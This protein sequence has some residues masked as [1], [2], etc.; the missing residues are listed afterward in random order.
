M[1]L[2]ENDRLRLKALSVAGTGGQCLLF[3]P[4]WSE[5]GIPY[6]L[7]YLGGALMNFL[8]AALFLVLYLVCPVNALVSALFGALAI[9][10]LAIGLMNAIP[11]RLALLDND[12]RSLLSMNKNPQAVFAFYRMMQIHGQIAGGLRLKDM[13]DEWFSTP[14]EGDL[15]NSL[16]AT[17]EVYRCNRLLDE[18]K[19]AQAAERIRALTE[20][21]AAIA[22]IHRNL[23]I[24]DLAY[25]ALMMGDLEAADRALDEQQ[26]KFMKTM[27]HFPSILRTQYADSLLSNHDA[28]A[29]ATILARFMRIA[30]KYPYPS[31]IE[32]ER[33]LMRAAEACSTQL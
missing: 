24:C 10:G 9:T 22:G 3:P 33:E 18:Q 7:Y 31:D 2:K 13:P 12:G 29:A 30:K 6:R 8:S 27:K 5:A 21:D 14:A 16:I 32:S 20:S 1:L 15:Q 4:E 17:I 19:I 28:A 25:C 11:L 23:L 26:R